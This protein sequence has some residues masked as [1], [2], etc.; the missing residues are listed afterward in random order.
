MTRFFVQAEVFGVDFKMV[1]DSDFNVLTPTPDVTSDL[2][3]LIDSYSRCTP[4]LFFQK[5]DVIGNYF[6]GHSRSCSVQK[7]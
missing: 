5:L 7:N 1:F 3:K 2:K 4:V 6:A